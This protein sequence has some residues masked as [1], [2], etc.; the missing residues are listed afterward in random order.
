MQLSVLVWSSRSPGCVLGK[1]DVSPPRV[2]V[3]VLPSI[4]NPN[5]AATTCHR[6]KSVRQASR[7]CCGN[8]FQRGR[9]FAFVLPLTLIS[10]FLSNSC[11]C[12]SF[13]APCGG[14][15]AA[16]MTSAT[17]PA[18]IKQI[19]K[20]LAR[21]DKGREPSIKLLYVTP[22]RL[23]NSDSML[24][25]MHRLH[26]QVPVAVVCVL[27]LGLGDAMSVCLSRERKYNVSMCCCCCCFVSRPFTS[28][29]PCR[30]C[31]LVS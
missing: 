1:V 4:S 3:A 29:P 27:L 12:P 2:C 22:E 18:L 21:A 5:F 24:G 14:I 13:Q 10:F 19:Y 6:H 7:Q 30:G 17:S 16:H 25:F 11:N 9:L 31:W 26:A 15:P 20:D 23:G 8:V 28:G